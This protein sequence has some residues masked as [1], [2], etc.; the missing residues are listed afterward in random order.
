M[1][2]LIWVEITKKKLIFIHRRV[3]SCWLITSLSEKE[4]KYIGILVIFELLKE[5]PKFSR[6]IPQPVRL[7]VIMSPSGNGGNN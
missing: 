5:V 2:E 7:T 4:R 1:A 6:G 3:F